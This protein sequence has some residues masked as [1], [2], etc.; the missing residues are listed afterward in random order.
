[1]SLANGICYS[2]S[3]YPGD[4][5]YNEILDVDNEGYVLSIK[6]QMGSWRC[7][8]SESMMQEGAAEH[9]WSMFIGQRQ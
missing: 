3:A 6:S 5:S 4:S 1:L 2:T 8:T 7:V 9:L